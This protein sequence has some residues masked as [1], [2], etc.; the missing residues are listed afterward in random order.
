M[1]NGEKFHF[2]MSEA[3]PNNPEIIH[4]H[5]QFCRIIG[6]PYAFF[7]K[8]RPAVQE[9]ICN[10]WLKS[11]APGEENALYLAKLRKGAEF[12]SIRALLPETHTTL[13]NAD[14][15]GTILSD[16]RYDLDLDTAI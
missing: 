16:D 5:K 13:T 7:S 8:N 14:I 6:V 10:R 4:A 2:K 11:L 9:D 12:T 3:D 15:V 1:N